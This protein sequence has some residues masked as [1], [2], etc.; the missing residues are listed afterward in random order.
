MVLGSGFSVG[1][2]GLG[3]LGGPEDLQNSGFRA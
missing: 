1:L 3:F 2:K